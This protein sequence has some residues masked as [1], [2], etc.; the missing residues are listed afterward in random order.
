MSLAM[1]KKRLFSEKPFLES[2]Q[3]SVKPG[4]LRLR[5]SATCGKGLF[6]GCRR[7]HSRPGSLR[8]LLHP[9]VLFGVARLPPATLGSP[10]R[11]PPRVVGISPRLSQAP[12]HQQVVSERY[13]L[14]VSRNRPAEIRIQ[15]LKRDWGKSFPRRSLDGSTIVCVPMPEVQ[16]PVWLLMYLLCG[17]CFSSIPVSGFC[18]KGV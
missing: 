5:G 2:T 17:R 7:S 4:N 11:H 9:A 8:P 14:K 16:I 13:S 15:Y 3:N 1:P 10:F 6:R 12:W 18:V